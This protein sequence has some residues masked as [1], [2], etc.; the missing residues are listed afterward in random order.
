M[1]SDAIGAAMLADAQPAPEVAGLVFVGKYSISRKTA[2]RHAQSQ[3]RRQAGG[4]VRTEVQGAGTQ[5]PPPLQ[6][7]R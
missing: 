7:G 1:A 5:R 2:W 6:R 3:R 4:R